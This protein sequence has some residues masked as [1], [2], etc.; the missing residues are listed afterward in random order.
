MDIRKINLKGNPLEGATDD[1]FQSIEDN[2][3]KLGDQ[4]AIKQSSPTDLSKKI[5]PELQNI[6]NDAVDHMGAEEDLK[7]ADHNTGEDIE[8]RFQE[9]VGASIDTNRLNN[10]P[11]KKQEGLDK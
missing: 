6:I 5:T 2:L 11:T 1:E 7:A 8:S 10:I 3:K 9:N 4:S